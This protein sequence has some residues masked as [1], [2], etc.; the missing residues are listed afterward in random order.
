VLDFSKLFGQLSCN[1]KEVGRDI[2]FIYGLFG[3]YIKSSFKRLNNVSVFKVVDSPSESSFFKFRFKVTIELEKFF[4][5]KR[6]FIFE[7]ENPVLL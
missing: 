4:T 3:D 7:S 2:R 1:L 6:L 5:C